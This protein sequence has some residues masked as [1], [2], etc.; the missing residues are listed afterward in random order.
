LVQGFDRVASP[1]GSR[2]KGIGVGKAEGVH[3][4]DQPKRVIAAAGDAVEQ[5]V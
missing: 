4:L 1:D 3:A 2:L 5:L